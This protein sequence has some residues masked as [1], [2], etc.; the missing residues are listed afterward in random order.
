MENINLKLYTMKKL[1]F[2]LLAFV[3]IT[4]PAFSEKVTDLSQLDNDELYFIS[5]ARATLLYSSAV[6]DMIATTT[7]KHVNATSNPLDENQ[8]FKIITIDDAYYLYSVGAQK[9]VGDKGKYT[10]EATNALTITY[11]NG[12]ANRPW[13]L[14]IGSN[15]FNSQIPNQTDEGIMMNGWSIADEGNRYSIIP[16]SDAFLELFEPVKSNAIALLNSGLY[17]S[18][19]AATSIAAIETISCGNSSETLD[20]AIAEVKSIVESTAIDTEE[21]FYVK[22]LNHNQ[23][24]TATSNTAFAGADERSHYAVWQF[25]QAEDG[26]YLLYEAA[27]QIYMPKTAKMYTAMNPVPQENAG[28]YDIL[29]VGTEAAVVFKSKD[30]TDASIPCIHNDKNNKQI[31]GWK[32]DA[33]ASQWQISVVP[34]EHREEYHSGEGFQLALRMLQSAIE[35]VEELADKMSDEYALGYLYSTRGNQELYDVLD[36]AKDFYNNHAMTAT[37]DQ[38]YA[39]AALLKDWA[40]TVDIYQPEFGHYY[41]AMAEDGGKAITA[42]IAANGNRLALEPTNTKPFSSIMYITQSGYLHSF[43]TGQLF[44]NFIGDNQTLLP[45][46]QKEGYTAKFGIGDAEETYTISFGK[47]ENDVQMYLCAID[48]AYVEGRSIENRPTGLKKKQFD[49]ILE[50]IT[51][52]PIV[53][54]PDG[55]ATLYTPTALRCPDGVVA[56]AGVINEEDGVVDLKPYEDGRIPAGTAVM[57]KAEESAIESVLGSDS[58]IVNL[59]ILESGV[60][61]EQENDFEGSYFTEYA[62]ENICTLQMIN[63]VMGFYGFNGDVIKGYK[64]YLPIPQNL[65]TL[66]LR[67]ADGMTTDIDAATLE[68]L[69]A[70][71]YDLSGRR[72]LNPTRGVYVTASGKKVFVK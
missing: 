33:Q 1:L 45:V 17:L 12:D 9:Y 27:R 54:S 58:K 53:V 20:A 2:L 62:P 11:N 42:N 26:G 30:P 49:W 5:S 59:S 41:R 66:R 7:G 69:P 6:P 50:E 25:K 39:K 46:G 64:A 4:I 55:F 70:E 61:A 57:I 43:S 40:S 8:Q 38:V 65:K 71:Y 37:L 29:F 56:Y 3:G 22:D 67:F 36:E 14:S 23:Y 28:A 34:D 51:E 63:G 13:V 52:L 10:D 16:V 15:Y 21:T 48:K 31:V 44:S 24:L 72:V 19:A 32:A 47:D 68:T 35:E 18:D 60:V